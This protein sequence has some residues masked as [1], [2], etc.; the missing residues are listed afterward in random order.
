MAHIRGHRFCFDRWRELGNPGWGYDDVLPLFK[1]SER[2]ESGASEFRGGDGPLAVA[3]ARTRTTRH[4]AFL[5]AAST[6]GYR[7]DARFDFNQPTPVN[8]AGYYQKNILDGKRH[9][10]AAAFLVAGVVAAEPR[11]ALA[12]QRHEAWSWKA[13]VW[14]ASSTIRDGQPR[15]V[16]AAREIVLAAASSIR[17]SC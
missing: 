2:N 15:A 9:S 7:S 3:T 1:R 5:A 13:R 16:R 14:W 11:G 8:V 17:P 6:H 4:R 10:A 12:R